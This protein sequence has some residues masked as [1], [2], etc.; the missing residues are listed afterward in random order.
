MGGRSG[1]SARLDERFTN[2]GEF[3]VKPDVPEAK[4]E[5][6]A[7]EQKPEETMEEKT[8]PTQAAA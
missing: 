1:K 5:P 7:E 2:E 8:E 3:D 6:V 4:A